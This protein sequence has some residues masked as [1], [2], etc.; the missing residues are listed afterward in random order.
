[1][2]AATAGLT[3]L[4]G[5]G[6]SGGSDTATETT[7]T[8]SSTD[9]NGSPSPDDSDTGGDGTPSEDAG[10]EDAAPN[11]CPMLPGTYTTFDPGNGPLPYSFEYP[12]VIDE[13]PTPMD[14]ANRERRTIVTGEVRRDED[15][16]AEGDIFMDANVNLNPQQPRDTWYENR[17]DRDTLLTTTV[18]GSEVRFIA[19]TPDIVFDEDREGYS[20]VGLAP[21]DWGSARE[22]P[23][24]TRESYHEVSMGILISLGDDTAVTS[25]CAGNLRA[26]L[27]HAVESIEMQS[28]VDLFEERVQ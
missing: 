15:L 11:A 14:Y 28:T 7:D 17:S 8:N 5:C 6:G 18:N 21:Y 20:A 3:G 1:L 23:T 12:A 2:L 24:A 13:T 10:G 22:S 4:A 27:E 25:S 26:T 19:T 9:P 16:P